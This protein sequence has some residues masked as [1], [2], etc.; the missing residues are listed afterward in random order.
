[1][2]VVKDNDG[3]KKELPLNRIKTISVNKVGVSLSSQLI[4]ECANRGIKIFLLDFKGQCIAEMIGTQHHATCKVRQ[5]QYEYL[6][7]NQVATL[8][9]K[10]IIAK[11]RNQRAVLLYFNKYL[12][13]TQPVKS[14][15]LLRT[16]NQ[17]IDIIEK[18]KNTKWHKHDLWRE[19]IMGLE[20]TAAALYWQILAKT[21]LLPKFEKRIGRG[22]KDIGNKTLNYGYAIITTTI[23][24]CLQNAGLE[25]YAGILHAQ[26]PG[27]PAL[28]L[29]ILEE[30]RPWLVDRMIIKHRQ[31]LAKETELTP[32]IKK[33]LI[34]SSISVEEVDKI[35]NLLLKSSFSSFSL[36]V[37]LLHIVNGSLLISGVMQ[38][39]IHLHCFFLITLTQNTS[40]NG[41]AFCLNSDLFRHLQRNNIPFPFSSGHPCSFAV[42]LN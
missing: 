10:I 21:E 28:V 38:Y 3:C 12:K 8:S 20:G 5:H 11:L 9:A 27:K 4:I 39:L 23:W 41:N 34:N 25:I 40:H 36:I 42:Q 31:I 35:G 33:I 17:I 18:L 30:Y 32:K 15:K 7:T 29:D 16:A 26:R 24:H 13:N 19:E 1:M 2:L 6:K 37:P 14:V 22:A